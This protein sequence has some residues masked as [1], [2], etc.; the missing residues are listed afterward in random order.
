MLRP[1]FRYDRRL[2]GKLCQVAS[3]VITKSFRALTGRP[4]ITVGMVACVQTFG[5][6][7]NFHP[8]LHILV[9]DGGLAPNGTFYVLPKVSLSGLEQLFRHRVLK[10]RDPEPRPPPAVPE[11]VDI[12][13]VPFVDS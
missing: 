1:Y 6:F 5:N 3:R 12:Q 4:D 9:T 13:Y 10:M 7:A 8:H 11:Q 2:L